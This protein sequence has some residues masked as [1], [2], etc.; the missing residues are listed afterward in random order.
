M[1]RRT[2][3]W[4][5]TVVVA[6]SPARCART[7]TA[8]R[9]GT[10]RPG[11][12]ARRDVFDREHDR[13]AVHRVVRTMH[14]ERVATPVLERLAAGAADGVA[15]GGGSGAVY[16][17]LDG[18]VLAL[19]ARGVPLMP[20]GIAVE[21]VDGLAAGAVVRAAPG[22]VEGDGARVVWDA[23]DPPAWEPA[24]RPAGP[25]ARAALGQ[26][27]AAI[28]AALG[29]DGA[30]SIAG[31]MAVTASG[32]GAEGA[33]HLRR[34]LVDRDPAAAARAGERRVG[35]GGGLTPEGD[36]VL[37]A[38]AAVVAAVGDAVGFMARDRAAWLAALVPADAGERTTAL[39]ATL[40]RL[41]ADGRI[42]EPVHP[43]LDTGDARWREALV[44]L[45]GAGAS[46]GRAYAVAVGATL[47]VLAA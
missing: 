30:P 13:T 20:N 41:A 31:G 28:L 22:V 26:R 27:G 21:R 6:V 37:A 45:E 36:D 18:F 33:T 35:L 17:E 40:L 44:R 39:S 43:L 25:E 5:K 14:A 24:L 11:A 1:R 2:G 42:V 10:N 4:A 47:R 34:A 12:A 15:R 16:V 7:S 9:A 32:R 29:V 23:G 38:T 8:P 3:A 19:T 46:T